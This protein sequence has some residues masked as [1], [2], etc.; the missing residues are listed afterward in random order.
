MGEALGINHRTL[1]Y[2]EREDYN[3]GL[4]MA[5]RISN[6]FGVPLGA[7]FAQRPF[8]SLADQ[9]NGREPEDPDNGPRLS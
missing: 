7:V 2:I 4:G 9:I 1:G 6:F 3:I 5:Y 8:S